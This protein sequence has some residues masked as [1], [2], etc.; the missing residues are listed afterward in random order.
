MRVYIYIYIQKKKVQLRGLV[1][2]IDNIY[3]IVCGVFVVLMKS[4]SKLCVSKKEEFV[5]FGM[6]VSEKARELD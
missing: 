1:P 4:I 3:H 6:R 2:K 5:D